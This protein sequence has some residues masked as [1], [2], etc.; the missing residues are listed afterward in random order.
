MRPKNELQH[1][2]SESFHVEL[3][4]LIDMNHVFVRL[5]GNAAV[6]IP[7]RAL[8]ASRRVCQHLKRIARRLARSLNYQTYVA[9]T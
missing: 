4:R 8:P 1:P 5:A 9:T 7:P 3:V 2:Q 6:I